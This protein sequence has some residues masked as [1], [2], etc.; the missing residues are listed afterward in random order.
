MKWKTLDGNSTLPDIVITTN[1][2]QV[3]KGV[4]YQL[5]LLI[6]MIISNH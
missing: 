2:E 5:N 4:D 1:K 6:E 3:L